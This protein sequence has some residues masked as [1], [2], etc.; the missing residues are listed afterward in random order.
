MSKNNKKIEIYV[1]NRIDK[2]SK[3]VPNSLFVPIRC[4]A[5]FDERENI[6]MLGDDT[7]DNISEYRNNL[8][9][10]TVLYWAWKNSDA[11]YIGLS[12]YRRFFSFSDEHMVEGDLKLVYLDNMSDT[13]LEKAGLLDEK[14]VRDE[15]EKCDLIIANSYDIYK[16]AK[17]NRKIKNIYECWIKL[18]PE[19]ISRNNFKIMFDEI[20]ESY[21]EY[22][23]DALEVRNGRSFLGFNCCVGKKE[24]IKNLCEF[25]FGT[26]FKVMKKID[27][28]D[29]FSEQNLR[30]SGY[31]CEWLFTIWCHHIEKK[32]KYNI[33][34]KQLI[35]FHDTNVY[36]DLKPQGEAVPIIYKAAHD[37]IPEIAVSIQSLVDSN[38]YDLQYD[39]ILLMESRLSGDEFACAE[40]MLLE[41]LKKQ[42]S[43]YSNVSLRVFNPQEKI[44]VLE[45]R[46]SNE[47][48]IKSEYCN[49]LLPWILEKYSRILVFSPHV[50]VLND[51]TPLYKY[52]LGDKLIGACSDLYYM[53]T[54]LKNPNISHDDVK[55]INNPYH[56]VSTDV[57]LMDL[58][59]IRLRYKKTEIV[60]WFVNEGYSGDVTF[61]HFYE[62]DIA[63]LDFKWN[64]FGIQDEFF[65]I[66]LRDN[67][68]KQVK[69]DYKNVT[70]P[71]I[72]NMRTQGKVIPLREAP[73]WLYFWENARNTTFYE[74][75]ISKCFCGAY[76]VR[77]LSFVRRL[78]DKFLPK[79]SMWRE[80]LKFIMPRGSKQFEAL[81]R[82]YHAIALD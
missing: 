58:D 15:I 39:I 29:N 24:I 44:D 1:S 69:D 74:L 33:Q 9:E 35:A 7:G 77:Q 23:D 11:D 59:K 60:E 37:T 62:D 71:S 67:I 76:P 5:C 38:D 2:E 25:L 42:I 27:V 79:G 68:P 56:Y 28:N 48:S 50:I 31:M 17:A 47:Q 78:A 61:N 51:I 55:Y 57:L 20:K 64:Y 63:R 45:R 46:G 3:Q 49:T 12:H 22:Y 6:S 14:K 36:V 73:A 8:C 4:G 54:V 75:L 43:A 80:A 65:N 72:L 40:N 30:V 19:F 53:D 52:N 81:K 21:P 26:I 34:K 10:L 18:C 16:D 70:E 66:M 32:N 82:L 41:R 13:N